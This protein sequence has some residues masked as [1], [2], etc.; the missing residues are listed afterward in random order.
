MKGLTYDKAF[1]LIL[2]GAVLFLSLCSN[3]Q[4]TVN[5]GISEKEHLY[6]L[7]IFK[8]TQRNEDLQNDIKR[9]KQTLVKDSTFV[10][11]AS[12]SQIDSLFT[13]YFRQP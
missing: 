12:V 11:H 4:V 7:E 3:P 6:R 2:I 1:T 8:L 5:Q 13:N 10:A 9:F